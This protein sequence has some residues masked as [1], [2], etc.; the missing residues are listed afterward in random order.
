M[1]VG[2]SEYLGNKESSR[3]E[4]YGT[5]ISPVYPAII[6]FRKKINANKRKR[7]QL[8]IKQQSFVWTRKDAIALLI[9]LCR[10]HFSGDGARGLPII[11]GVLIG[12]ISRLKQGLQKIRTI[13][14]V[15]VRHIVGESSRKIARSIN[16]N[17]NETKLIFGN[18]YIKERIISLHDRDCT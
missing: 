4:C 18:N 13:A 3:A 6:R 14:K 11:P 8:L 16:T 15:L 2:H 9:I 1:H 7:T 17:A 10:G 12:H 5:L